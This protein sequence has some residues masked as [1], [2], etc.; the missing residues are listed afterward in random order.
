MKI[1]LTASGKEKNSLLSPHFGRCSYFAIYDDVTGEWSFEENAAVYETSGAGIKA[2]QHV[3]DREAG[4][5]LTG[6]VGPK[7]WQVLQSSS[8]EVFQISEVPLEEALKQYREGKAH[9]LLSASTGAHSGPLPSSKQ[10]DHQ[11]SSASGKKRIAVATDGDQ[12]ARHFG[13]CQ[14]YTMVNYQNGQVINQ[15]FIPNPGHEPGFLPR[16][17]GEQGINCVIAG[18][19]G[20]RAQQL[21]KEQDISFVVGVTGLVNEVVDKFIKGELSGG[22]SLCTHD[23]SGGGGECSHDSYTL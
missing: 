17:L 10:A 18:G 4:V 23:D 1:V 11:N 12:V 14:G 13:R 22:D 2:A 15:S 8:L 3:L 7:A 5:V 21:F 6:K 9:N 19:M 20:G 16:F